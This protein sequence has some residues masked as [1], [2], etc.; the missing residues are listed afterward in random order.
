MKILKMCEIQLK[1]VKKGAKIIV[2]DISRTTGVLVEETQKW[3][4][5]YLFPAY[6]KAGLNAI[7]TIDSEA[8]I[9]R[10]AAKRWTTGGKF[11]FDLVIVKSRQEA[12]KVV[13]EYL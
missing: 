11:S 10:L 13:T 12:L 9:I 8:P 4:Q 5:N 6:A 2:V 7:I 1:Q 3:L